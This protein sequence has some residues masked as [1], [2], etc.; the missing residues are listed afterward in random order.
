[1]P[2]CPGWKNGKYDLSICSPGRTSARRSPGESSLASRKRDHLGHEAAAQRHGM[3]CGDA[4]NE[5]VVVQ[6]KD[7]ERRVILGKLRHRRAAAAPATIP[8][9]PKAATSAGVHRPLTS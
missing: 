6:G 4:L 2:R 8:A 7:P 5:D 1:M 9:V 3:A